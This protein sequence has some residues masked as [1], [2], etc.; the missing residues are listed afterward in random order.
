MFRK[1]DGTEDIPTK[2]MVYTH[3]KVN[4]PSGGLK[5]CIGLSSL[6]DYKWSA[7]SCLKKRCYVC[8]RSGNIITHM[9]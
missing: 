8:Q 1:N 2:A 3:W 9:F 7:F 5:D 6:D 4:E